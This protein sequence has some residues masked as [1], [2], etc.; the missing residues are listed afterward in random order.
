MK[1][2]NMLQ[3]QL[4]KFRRKSEYL[5]NFRCNYCSDSSKNANK[6]RGY[7]Y[8]RQEM[9]FYRCHNCSVGTTFANFLKFM[10][11]QLYDDYIMEKF[12][13]GEA[14]GRGMSA[15]KP[16]VKDFF[17]TEKIERL[18]IELPSVV[19][20]PDSIALKYLKDRKIPDDKLHLFYYAEDFQ[21]WAQKFTSG[22]FKQKYQTDVKDPR[23][24]IPFLDKNGKMVAL[25]A[26]TLGDSTLR[27]ITLKFDQEATKVYGLERWDPSQ[28]TYVLEGPIDSLF[29]PNSLAMAGS[30]VD[31]DY[32]FPD[33]SRVVYVLDNEKRNQEIVRLMLG[34]VSKGYGV[35][36]WSNSTVEKD[37]NDMILSG[38]TKEEIKNNIDRNTKFGLTAMLAIGNWRKC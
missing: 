6:A 34:A 36:V 18:E 8:K 32:L 2:L 19:D 16:V 37:V 27:Y 33:R 24:V 4:K 13:T 25:Q 22:T 9:L 10:N 14:S 7:I 31:I 26:R 12:T 35:C 15:A 29:L 11:Q 38:K 28:K 30:C 21:S 5:W 17:A 1:Y 23:I 20:L 3:H